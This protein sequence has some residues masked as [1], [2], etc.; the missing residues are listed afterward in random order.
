MINSTL[1]TEFKD[2]FADLVIQLSLRGECKIISSSKEDIIAE[3]KKS[4]MNDADAEKNVEPTI[5]AAADRIN[6]LKQFVPHYMQWIYDNGHITL[7]EFEGIYMQM[8]NDH[9]AYRYSEL[10][11]EFL[12]AHNVTSAKD[13]L[14][15]L[16]SV[17]M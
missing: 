12:K 15:K 6:T 3:L 11:T 5:A 16:E 13:Y 17:A 14:A 10:Q 8:R 4:G 1:I 9:A 2:L 7:E